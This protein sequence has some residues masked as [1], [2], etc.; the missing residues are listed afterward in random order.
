MGIN[1]H[2]EEEMKELRKI[3]EKYDK[4]TFEIEVKRGE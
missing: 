2:N 3:F 4:A 1:T